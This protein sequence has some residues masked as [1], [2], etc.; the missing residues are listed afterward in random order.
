MKLKKPPPLNVPA[1]AESG[2]PPV[3]LEAQ[4][5]SP[6]L[7]DHMVA[8]ID[9]KG[10]VI[11][12]EHRIEADPLKRAPLAGEKTEEKKEKKA[13]IHYRDLEVK[14]VIGRGAFGEVKRVIH[15]DGMIFALKVVRVSHT[16]QA[17]KSIRSE[18]ERLKA[19]RPRH[20]V[21][22]Y[23]AYYSRSTCT[24]NFLMEFMDYGSVEN[25]FDELK[26]KNKTMPISDTA[27]ITERVLYALHELRKQHIVHK[28]IKPAN[29]LINYKSEVKIG[30]FGI[31][32]FTN[33]DSE[34]LSGTG[35]YRWM[36]PERITTDT[37]S[38]NSDVYSLGFVV[39]YLALGRFPVRID[40]CQ[41]LIFMVDKFDKIDLSEL[42]GSGYDDLISFI[43]KSTVKRKEDRPFAEDLF[44]H[45]FIKN[46]V[47]PPGGAEADTL[48]FLKH[49]SAYDRARKR[50]L[51]TPLK[52]IGTDCTSRFD[53]TETICSL[54]SSPVS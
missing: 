40:T 26:A 41:D 19:R 23:E 28:D 45:P 27:C 12:G 33:K 15:K 35:S 37:F 3:L 32:S 54:P 43:H 34:A 42:K 10:D 5:Q 16:E 48:S 11:L 49:L 29:I 47:K 46:R 17:K 7:L 1:R 36:A 13:H 31:C 24:V 52:P 51:T 14:E 53:S 38:Y 30:D 22:T 20:A 44:E 25:C 9:D 50:L 21:R 4:Q 2:A 8:T 18:L 6:K 39:A